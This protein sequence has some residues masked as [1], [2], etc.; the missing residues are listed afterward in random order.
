MKEQLQII[1]SAEIKKLKDNVKSAK[2]TIKDFT[3]KTQ[4]DVEEATAAFG[5]MSDG[6]KSGMAVAGTAIAGAAT[7]LLA[8]ASS[9]KEYRQAQEQLT[10]AFEAAGGSAAEA[11]TTYNDLYRV[12]GDSG[13][14]IEAAQHLAKLTTNQQELSEW[15]NIAQGVYATFGASLPI[16]GLTE[17]A[18][19]TAKV[20]T[21]TGGLADALNWAGISE[22]AFNEKLAK[23]NDEAEREKL[24]R[25][26]LNSVYDDASK[27]YEENNKDVLAQNEAQAKLDATTAKLG[28]TLAP[29]IAA[30]TELAANVLSKISPYLQEFSDKYLP[31]IKDVLAKVGEYIGVVIGWIVD[32]WEI[33][34]TVATVVGAIAAAILLVNGAL[35]AYNVVM[36]IANAIMA[37]SPITWIVVGITALIAAIILCIVYWDEIK[38]AVFNAVSAIWEW[39]KGLWDSITNAISAGWE[40]ITGI[41]SKVG[42]WIYDNVISPV[43]EFF[44]GLWTGIVDTFNKVIMPWVEIIKRASQLIYDTVIKPIA[45]YFVGLW[46]KIKEVFSV[47]GSWF[48]EKVIQPIVK[49]FTGMWNGLKDGASKAWEGIK[50]V[51]SKV[52]DWFKDVFSK[53][54]QKVKDVF[55]TGGKI[56]NGIKEGIESVFKT[57]VN[58]I[59]RGINKVITIPFNAINGVLSKLKGI[60]ILEIKPFSWINTFS[61]PQI[62]ELEKG[63]VL[64]RGQVGLLEGNGTEAV[65]P[66]EKNTG[67]L[68]EIAKRLSANMG[69]NNAPMILKLQVDDKVL[70][71]VVVNGINDITRATGSLPLVIA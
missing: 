17:A 65:V 29:V 42:S 53:A 15:T 40:W 71:E 31:T 12:L 22:D 6:I 26:T 1:I 67:W 54:W 18:N 70:G 23:C 30:L 45:D 62:P 43:I 52:S 35:T 49:F 47:V 50:N 24:I 39:V 28:E 3:E 37:A 34:K 68:D 20:G 57:V 16:E 36:G 33:I 61:V 21:V 9:T 11:T 63:G 59:I 2:D 51:F 58:S 14:A 56:F 48:N 5:S 44:K 32:N 13:Q 25:E 41:L 69:G 66:L 46:N 4:K 55:S 27:K 7:A 10:T 60:E 19:E 38:A 8:L 64:K